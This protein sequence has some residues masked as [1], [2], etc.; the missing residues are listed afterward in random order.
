[1]DAAAEQVKISYADFG[2][3]KGQ[4]ALARAIRRIPGYS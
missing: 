2:E 3:V 4:S 1:M